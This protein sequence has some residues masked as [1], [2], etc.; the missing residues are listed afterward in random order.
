MDYSKRYTYHIS[1]TYFD[2]LKENNID[3]GLMSNKEN[4]AYR[5]TFLCF[6]DSKNSSIFW[7][8]PLSSKYA[9]YKS[10][11][12]N[13]EN[14]YGNCL[15]IV[16]GEYD[17]KDAA[18]LVQNAFPILPKYI[19]HT[20]TRNNNPVPVSVQIAEEVSDKLKRLI[21]LRKL[22]HKKVGFVDIESIEKLLLLEL[23]ASKSKS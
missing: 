4:N 12:I 20:H 17:G 8:V 7:M 2:W 9:K 13:Q 11:K 1:D 10:I 15:G 18:F 14:R 23:A 3:T 5:P 16:L 6:P 22:R 19:D 21:A